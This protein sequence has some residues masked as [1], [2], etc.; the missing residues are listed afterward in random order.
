MN[1]LLL[2]A[3]DGRTGISLCTTRGETYCAL[4]G[5]IVAA[6]G[7]AEIALRDAEGAALHHARIP[8]FTLP[9]AANTAGIKHVLAWLGERNIRVDL[10]AHR[11]EHHAEHDHILRLAPDR[12]STLAEFEACKPAVY[13][14]EAVAD[15]GDL[16]QVAFFAVR[17]HAALGIAR[18]IADAGLQAPAGCRKKLKVRCV[19][20][21][22]D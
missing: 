4:E 11:I 8:V 6:S 14:V 15:A 16:P 22:A 17:P 21:C 19:T 18:A 3:Q 5:E 1:I 7:V 9:G 13:C 2:A 10:V 20:C 12:V